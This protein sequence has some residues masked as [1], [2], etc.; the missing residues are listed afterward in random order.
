MSSPKALTRL[1]DELLWTLRRGGITIATSQAVDVARVAAAVG[2]E[3]R[4]AFKEALASVI[5]LRARDRAR[6]DELFDRF[7]ESN[8]P[9]GTLW[10]RLAAR[11][12]D[13]EEIAELREL[14]TRIAVSG[15]DR[16]AHLGALLQRGAELDRLLY[17][18]AG[19]RSLEA[20]N[21]L[22]LGF[23]THQ[24]LARLGVSRAHQELSAIRVRLRE[25]LGEARGN[26]LA[27]AL[28]LELDM[29]AEQAKSHVAQTLERREIERTRSQGPR[30][31]AGAPFASLSEAEVDEVRRAVRAFAQRL[32]GG[33]RVRTRHSRHGRIDPHRTLRRSLKTDGVP[34]SPARRSRVRDKPRL[35]LACDVSD[36]VRAVACFMLEF[37]YAAQ[38][39]FQRT[40]SFVFVSDLGET[41]ALFASEPVNVALAQ[42]YSGSVVSV[43]DNSNYGRVLRTF[44]QRFLDAVDRRTTVVILGDGRTNYHE[45]AADVLDRVRA[46]AK[47]LLWLCPEP[48]ADWQ[49]GDSAMSRYAPKC[50]QVLEVRCARDLETAARA[51]VA[52]R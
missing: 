29:A 30:T 31:L 43:A 22:Q 12:F 18:V 24:V 4:T 33:A 51:L 10:D 52:R 1:L 5:V 27:D 35:I 49:V 15:G 23:A 36:S 45:D 19:P 25:A 8:R 16:V 48:R 9:A 28:R 47:A 39:L 46:R 11:G 34:F 26:L 37:V 13:A 44:E 32:R 6:Y 42:A 38:E 17:L 50:T 3:D 7:F 41:T 21:R 20:V 14:L 40:R 2:F